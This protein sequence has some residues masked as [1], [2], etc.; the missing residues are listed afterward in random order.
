MGVVGLAEAIHQLHR[1]WP[2]LSTARKRQTEPIQSQ[3]LTVPS[4]SFYNPLV[5]QAC[6]ETTYRIHADYFLYFFFPSF[7]F[8]GNVVP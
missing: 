4:A 3:R 8:L 7:F 5:V 1:L 6:L 2:F